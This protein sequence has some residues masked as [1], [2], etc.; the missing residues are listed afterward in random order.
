M[1]DKPASEFV[2]FVPGRLGLFRVKAD[3]VL[4]DGDSL[5]LSSG[6]DVVAVSTP[7]GLALRADLVQMPFPL[8]GSELEV[9]PLL[10]ASSADLRG[11]AYRAFW[12]FLSGGVLGFIGGAG[13]ALSNAGFW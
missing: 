2:L 12:L 9:E 8:H 1:N 6:T 5:F 13:L 10:G 4:V 3:Q 7:R 11:A